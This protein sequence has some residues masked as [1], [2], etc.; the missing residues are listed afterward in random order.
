MKRRVDNPSKVIYHYLF[1]EVQ[2]LIKIIKLYILGVQ[3]RKLT[4]KL[5]FFFLRTWE[6]YGFSGI[7]I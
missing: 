4:T 1:S 2:N 5:M 3:T 7:L 6:N